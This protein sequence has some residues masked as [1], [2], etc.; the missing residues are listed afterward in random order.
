MRLATITNWAYGATLVLT[1]VS[2]TTMLLA[3]SAQ[4]AE[5][6]AVAQRFAL[7][8][9][10]EHLEERVSG[11]TDR[12]RQYLNTGDPTYAVLYKREL[13]ELSDAEKHIRAL[14]DAGARGDELAI[15]RDAMTWADALH[16]EQA[17]ALAAHA[18]GEERRARQILFGAEYERELDRARTSVERFQD[19]LDE[20]TEIE[21]AEAI[22]ISRLWRSM[23]EAMLAI[24]GFLFLCVLY[25]VFKRRVLR[26][27]V[28][29]SDVVNRLAAQDFGVE[30]P[31]Y[32]EIDEIGD[33]AQAI[34]IF[35]ENGIERQ[36]LTAEQ[37][38]DRAVRDL[39]AR[40]TQRMQGCDTLLNLRDVVQRFVPEIAPGLAG[41]L[42]L[43]D[44]ASNAMVE[45]CNWLEPAH[46]RP[47]FSPLSCWALRRG[48]PHRPSGEA[49]DVP[50]EHVDHADGAIPDTLCLP[51]M[52]QRKTLGLL[53]FEF[54]AADPH[55]RVSEVYLQI[56]AENISLALANLQL[57][58]TLEDMAMSDALTGLPNR[59][60]LDAVLRT[61]LIDAERMGTALSC[62][63]IDIDHFKRINDSHGHEAG[64]TVLR[65]VGAV[66][67]QATRENTQVFRYGGEEFLVMLPG[68]SA[69]QAQ[70]RAEDLRARIAGL[71]IAHHGER[72]APVSV[73]VGIATA[74]DHCT[75]ATLVQTADAALYRAKAQG[76]DQVVQASARA[77]RSAA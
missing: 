7:D 26:P 9:A 15:L 48:M 34:R 39:L 50:C 47:E 13:A 70:L 66:L 77:S 38:A 41:R 10:T 18:R 29:L 4:E 19:Q 60:Q 75:Y 11:L 3:A 64:D 62:L 37:D 2:G 27:V 28:R 58:E 67:R 72:L 61:R 33:M 40:M 6:S 65:E 16:D 44:P 43:A 36:R 68:A 25:F 17:E 30:P 55:A 20:R 21:I 35:R 71:Q 63:M 45:A 73:S 31:A 46:S 52:A 5:R 74:P 54:R 32:D 57:R 22:R 56:L 69:E 23:S 59:R 12:A 76:R 14:G 51:L 53:Y 49:I 42:Y 8:Q 24:T 1:L